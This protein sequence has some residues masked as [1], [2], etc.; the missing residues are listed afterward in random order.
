MA[1]AAGFGTLHN[2]WRD[3]YLVMHICSIRVLVVDL[4]FTRP[5]SNGIKAA[6][7]SCLVES[8]SAGP[9]VTAAGVSGNGQAISASSLSVQPSVGAQGVYDDASANLADHAGDSER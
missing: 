1:A 7:M 5:S 6:S 8:V 4:F 2:K 3:V 9:E